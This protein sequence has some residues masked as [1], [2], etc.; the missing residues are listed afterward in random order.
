MKKCL[1][2]G[3]LG[4]VGYNAALRHSR[5][6]RSVI[7]FDDVSR[8]TAR[9]NLAEFRRS[10]PPRTRLVRGDI[11]DAA[12]LRALFN[13]HGPFDLVVHLAAQVAVTASVADPEPD[14]DINARGTL[15]LL[16]AVRRLSPKAFVIFAST[17]KVYGELGGLKTALVEGRT[18]YALRRPRGG[19]DES[20]PLD[21]HSP[22]GCS[23]GAADQYVR[24]YARVYGLSTVVFR[25]SCIYGP[26]QYGETDQGWVAWFMIAAQGGLP[27]VVYGDGKQVRDAL[28]V[29]DLL[30][31][32]DRAWQRSA[33][34][35]GQVFNAG[36]G[37]GR[38]L[39]LLELLDWMR[40]RHGVKP[41]LSFREWR[42]GDQKVYVSDVSKAARL[43][44]WRPE[45]GLERG[46]ER[47]WRWLAPRVAASRR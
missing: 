23:K 41:P 21:F 3:G 39:S 11:R 31:L 34:C 38:T 27:I 42:P 9:R 19:I 36:G 10:P 24:D 17:N 25:Q 18:R 44:G 15:N 35:S 32:Y 8:G 13:R 5:R 40:L 12:A 4:F 30:A 2:T 29:D 43:L 33:A 37:P 7:L 45:I 46:L 1:I 47:L 20:A 22:Y 16:E 28:D 14:F 26:W 6:G